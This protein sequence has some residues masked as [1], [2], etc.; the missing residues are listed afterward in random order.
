MHYLPSDWKDNEPDASWL[1]PSEHDQENILGLCGMLNAPEVGYSF[2]PEIW[3]QGIATEAVAGLIKAFW[4]T[5]PSGHPA[6]EDE[7]KVYLMARTNKWNF[8]SEQVLKK[9]GFEWWE[10]IEDEVGGDVKPD[11]ATKKED[12]VNRGVSGGGKR[13]KAINVWRLW[14][15]GY[16]DRNART[17]GETNL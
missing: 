9:N 11:D 14:R 13:G 5:F 17:E 3:G 12:D 4:E 1:Q 15:S 16:G 8:A 6:L 2:A 10:E 7:Q